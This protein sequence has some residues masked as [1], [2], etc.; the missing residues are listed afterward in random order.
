[1][2][3]TP[4]RGSAHREVIVDYLLPILRFQPMMI[5]D[6]HAACLH[7]ALRER[8]SRLQ[9]VG[10]PRAKAV[11]P[12]LLAERGATA[13]SLVCAFEYGRMAS[14]L[15][16]FHAARRDGNEYGAGASSH[17]PSSTPCSRDVPDSHLHSSRACASG[18]DS[19]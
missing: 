15:G 19:W 11:S 7:D 4:A 10:S 8:D 6:S 12:A 14:A 1:M 13:V 5:I 17:E 16:I 2:N 9:A 3:A 18:R